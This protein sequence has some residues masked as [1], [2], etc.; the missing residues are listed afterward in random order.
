MWDEDWDLS[1]WGWGWRTLTYKARSCTG[2]CQSSTLKWAAPGQCGDCI[3]VRGFPWS[4]W[5]RDGAAWEREELRTRGSQ[6]RG[7]DQEGSDGMPKPTVRLQ[8]CLAGHWELQLAVLQGL[9]T[10]PAGQMLCLLQWHEEAILPNRSFTLDNA[11]SSDF[12]DAR[13]K[14]LSAEK[15]RCPCILTHID[16]QEAQIQI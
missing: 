16:H 9:R 5:T 14:I 11:R 6:A 2:R 4:T 3:G 15:H 1:T 13:C 7:W 8:D 12:Q 10:F